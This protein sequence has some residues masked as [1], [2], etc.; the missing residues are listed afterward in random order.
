MKK[1]YSEPTLAEQ[2]ITT[3]TIIAASVDIN[4]GEDQG[5]GSTDAGKQRGKWGNLWSK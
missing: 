3:N 4:V 2:E 1:R 5:N